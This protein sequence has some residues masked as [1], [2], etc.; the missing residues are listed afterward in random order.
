MAWQ[1]T[2]IRRMEPVD[3]HGGVR[4]GSHRSTEFASF[5]P[6]EGFTAFIACTIEEII[7]HR[8][9]TRQMHRNTHLGTEV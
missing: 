7:V 1:L 3:M 6:P 4:E 5:S 8:E 9:M 2:A